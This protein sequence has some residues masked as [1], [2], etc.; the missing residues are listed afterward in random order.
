MHLKQL[1]S[2]FNEIMHVKNFVFYIITFILS[3][4]LSLLVF[5]PYVKG[6]K[7]L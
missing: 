1:T 6:F 4:L 5:I 2:A 7:Y 3:L